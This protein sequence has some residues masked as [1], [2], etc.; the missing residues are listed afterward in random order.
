[1]KKLQ[2][3]SALTDLFSDT[4]GEVRKDWQLKKMQTDPLELQAELA[5]SSFLFGE[6]TVPVG[7]QVV[8]IGRYSAEKMGILSQMGM[9]GMMNDLYPGDIAS[10][11]KQIRGNAITVGIFS[12][13]FFSFFHGILA[14]LL[15]KA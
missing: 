13:V 7:Q 14:L 12:L 2:I 3:F 11:R 4:D 10:V 6:K 8:A 5:G 9:G 15:L 1:M